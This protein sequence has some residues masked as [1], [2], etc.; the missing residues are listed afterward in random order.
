VTVHLMSS[1]AR[2]LS[3]A[4]CGFFIFGLPLLLWARGGLSGV[5]LRV[6]EDDLASINI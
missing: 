2:A 6:L 1:A 3:S 4:V 5:V